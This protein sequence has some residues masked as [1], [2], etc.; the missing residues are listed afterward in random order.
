[1]NSLL[2]YIRQSFARNSGNTVIFQRPLQFLDKVPFR[3]QLGF[4]ENLNKN[5]LSKEGVDYQ[6]GAAVR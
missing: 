4:N 3:R 1:M 5:L 6:V 2:N